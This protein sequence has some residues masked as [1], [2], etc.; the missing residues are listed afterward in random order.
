[1]AE[2]HPDWALPVLE[3]LRDEPRGTNA[4]TEETQN[5]H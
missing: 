4:S 1:M 3:Y 2:S 5:N